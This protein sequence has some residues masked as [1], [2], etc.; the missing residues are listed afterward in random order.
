MV[1]RVLVISRPV[2]YDNHVFS[3]F[4]LSRPSLLADRFFPHDTNFATRFTM[5]LGTSYNLFRTLLAVALLCFMGCLKWSLL[6]LTHTPDGLGSVLVHLYYICTSIYLDGTGW[7]GP[8]GCIE[9]YLHY[10]Y[11]SCAL[12]L[13]YKVSDTLIADVI[14]PG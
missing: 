9:W 8:K 10:Y 6:L 4:R 1:L 3:P 2:V 7:D 5:Q 14:T 11:Y 12:L 13:L